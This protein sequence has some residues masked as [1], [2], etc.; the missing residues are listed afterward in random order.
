MSGAGIGVVRSR[1][2]M[3]QALTVLI[4]VGVLQLMTIGGV[5]PD[6]SFPRITDDLG[7]LGSLLA[8]GS[9]W[10][11]VGRT[12]QGWA[13]GLGLATVV[14]LPL[15]LLIGMNQWFRSATNATI[16]FLRPVPSV[17]LI[18]LAVLVLGTGIESKVFLA[19]FAALW[20]ILIGTIYG[21]RDVDPVALD[22]AR[23]FGIRRID[24]L[25]SILLPGALPY[26]ATGFRVAS[27]TALILAV[28]AELVI[29]MPGL[30]QEIVI[31][32]A[33]SQVSLMYALIIATGLLGLV[34]NVVIVRTERRLLSW[35]SAY[36]GTKA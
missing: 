3:Y 4:V 23:S 12:L 13:L 7:Q 25:R 14:A 34:L 24:R 18:P 22:T 32:Q 31:A 27:A 28:T 19:A 10:E 11:A 35:H 15:G 1:R 6:T 33:S 20:P 26:V 30:G 2:L 8:E 17:A 16:E 29:G 9:F 36:R 5:L 21:V